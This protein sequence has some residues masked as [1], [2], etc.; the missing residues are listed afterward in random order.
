MNELYNIRNKFE[1]AGMSLLRTR[2]RP[3]I[4]SSLMSTNASAAKWIW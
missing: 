3:L 2:Q 4:G 1:P